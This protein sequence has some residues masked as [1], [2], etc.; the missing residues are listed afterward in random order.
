MRLLF[1]L[2]LL[3]LI[4]PARAQDSDVE[5]LASL[6]VFTGPLDAVAFS[7]DGSILASGGRDNT[8]RFWNA[9]TGELLR[10][11]EGHVDWVSSVAFSPD[12]NFL[13]SGSRDN[14]V[15]RFDTNSGELLNIVGAHD[16]DVTAVAI[17][18]DGSVIASGSRDSN[19]KLWD[20]ET[21]QQLDTLNQFLQPVWKLAFHP[22]GTVL[23]SS[24]EDG[25]IWLWGLWGHHSGWLK[26]LVGHEGAVSSIAFSP[27]GNYLLSGGLDGTVRLWDIGDLSIDEREATIIMQGHLAPVMGL[28]FSADSTLGIS[29]SL[30][31]TVRLWDLAGSIEEGQEL[32]E[33]HGNGA[34]LTYLTLN[35]SNQ[36][37]VSV[38]TDGVL[39]LWDISSE[40][41]AR[42][43]ESNRPL[44][45]V[46][47]DLASSEGTRAIPNGSDAQSEIES[48]VIPTPAQQIAEITSPLSLPPATTGRLLTIPT[49]NISSAV[50]TF[51]LDGV[52][53][54]IDPW[55]DS[56]GHL[57]GTSWLNQT[58]NVVIGGHSEMPDGTAG[59]FYRLYNLGIGDE[60][61]LQDGDL[62]RR[63]VVVNILS[64]DYRELSVVYPTTHNR[65]TLITCDIP[66]YVAEQ[67]IY[68]ERL[69]IVA[70]EV[71]L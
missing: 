21:A 25:I 56:V 4:V 15:R 59:V 46:A 11:T 3:L 50:T 47:N 40:T 2:S 18:P 48:A 32:S 54:A 29:A 41:I 55:E 17:S 60:I 36:Q 28:G 9:A 62:S 14:T 42:V 66:S 20:S 43:I 58:G 64:V 23:A 27:D 8:I 22:N 19:I 44:S 52:S 1:F 68:Y 6:Q 70:D 37:A 16:G 63:Y 30:D 39:N 53:W 67:N 13:I 31:G 57:Q 45:I 61:F 33:L 65:L 34:P 5:L 49:A 71:P 7:P 35:A 24:S 10:L 26:K 69:V 51:Y 38:G 12:G